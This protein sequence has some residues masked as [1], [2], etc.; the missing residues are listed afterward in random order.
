M[1]DDLEFTP[2]VDDKLT[3]II[4]DIASE[5]H[6][7][8]ECRLAELE[9]TIKE[10]YP[11]TKDTSFAVVYFDILALLYVAA[12]HSISLVSPQNQEMV[13]QLI[14]KYWDD[15]LK[16]ILGSNE[17]IQTNTQALKIIH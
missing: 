3:S 1:H 14:N 8:I 11:Q 13:Q 17:K 5:V 12:S 16:Q 9:T 6:D 15:R 4:K 10:K 7:L 2:Q